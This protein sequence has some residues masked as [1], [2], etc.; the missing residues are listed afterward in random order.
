MCI[1]CCFNDIHNMF[2]DIINTLESLLN[3]SSFQYQLL[4]SHYMPYAFGSGFN[5]YK[6]KRQYL[7]IVWDGRDHIVSIY[8]NHK[9]NYPVNEWELKF[10]GDINTFKQL[11]IK[12]IIDNV[13]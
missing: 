1:G 8:S 3:N 9:Q 12:F 4:E 13:R 6:L 10:E 5:A 2:A 7:R 11:N